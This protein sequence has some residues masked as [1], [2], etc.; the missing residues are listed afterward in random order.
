MLGGPKLA[1][2]CREARER[3]AAGETQRGVDRSYN[4]NEA[5]ISRLG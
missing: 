1:F 2:L 3:L 4:V 5:T